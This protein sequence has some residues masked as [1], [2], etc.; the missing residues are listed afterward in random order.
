MTDIDNQKRIEFIAE[1]A[2]KACIL[3]VSAPKPG[4]VNREY[5]FKDTAY[6]D[7]ILGSHAIKPAIAE[8]AINGF[9]AGIGKIS[10]KEI[11]IGNYIKNA[12][13]RVK[14]S[15]SGGNTHLGICL[16]L[17]P[18][19]AGAGLCMAQ[20]KDF[21]QLRDNIQKI[22]IATT[23]DDSISFYDAVLLSS[24]HGLNKENELDVS[25][26]D[27]KNKLKEL[28]MNFYRLMRYSTKK[29]RIA[30]ELYNG[31][32]I[33][34]DIGVPMLKKI[35]ERVNDI[36]SAIV[37]TY[38]VILSRYPDTL[39]GKKVGWDKAKEVSL[40]AEKVL[41]SGGILADENKE[42]TEFDQFLRSDGNKLNPGTTADIITGTLMISL[43]Q[44]LRV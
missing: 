32:P 22:L 5:D 1:C 17:V 10:F 21:G 6:G 36:N 19:A 7:F 11:R 16:L 44:G 29:D 33:I 13:I 15:H 8:A 9:N 3:E 34:F 25:E 38:L 31:M 23:V 28:D 24:T 18:I 37:Q 39:I 40:Y 12:V 14:K 35:Y 41:G 4:N 26:R 30:Q 27:S 20:R 2:E 43:L 42:I